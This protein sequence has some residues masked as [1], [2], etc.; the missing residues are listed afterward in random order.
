V[1]VEVYLLRC[2]PGGRLAYRRAAGRLGASESPDDAAGRIAMPPAGQAG[3]MAVHS[4]SWRHRAD[5]SIV[6]TYAVLPDPSPS[7]PAVPI[8]SFGIARGTDP[9]RPSPPR[10]HREEVAAHAARH[11]A[12]LADTDPVVRQVLAEY[13]ELNCALTAL[14]RLPAGQL[15]A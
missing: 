14:P 1:L 2:Q 9:R 10:V 12:L 11:L 13:P 5:G 8:T 15:P 6:L 3:P 4:T 7:L